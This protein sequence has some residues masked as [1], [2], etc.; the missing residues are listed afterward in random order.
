MPEDVSAGAP[1]GQVAPTTPAAPTV[2]DP[3]ELG[4]D[5]LIRVKGVDKPVKFSDHVRGFQ[6]QFTK[7][8]QQAAQLKRELEQERAARAAEKEA[9]QKQ[10]AAPQSGQP[11][12]FEALRQLPYLTGKDAVEVVQ[13]IGNQ[14]QQRDQVLLAA[15]K[16]MQQMEQRLGGLYDTHSTQAFEA[17]IAKWL[18][19]GEYPDEAA[20]LAKDIYMGYE[21]DDLDAEFPRIFKERWEQ[22]ERIMEARRQSALRAAKP[23]PFVPGKGGATGP[24]K[25]L[26]LKPNASAAQ[27]ADSLWDS[28]QTDPTT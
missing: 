7:A 12:V 6:S 23:Q 18:K 2:P 10:H 19:E 8:S 17:K 24:S 28:L 22:V 1:Q 25:P 21:G 14:I 26:T 16:K 5:T 27:I 11:D 13:Q 4:D 15:L 9:W 20:E 3:I